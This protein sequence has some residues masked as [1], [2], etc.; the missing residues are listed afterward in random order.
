VD[1]VVATNSCTLKDK[2]RWYFW[3]PNC[4]VFYLG[5]FCSLYM[6]VNATK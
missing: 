5:L 1:F 3:A 4:C 2:T 6:F